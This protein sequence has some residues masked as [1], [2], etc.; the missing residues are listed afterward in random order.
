MSTPACKRFTV[1]RQYGGKLTCNKVLPP[2]PQVLPLIEALAEAPD[3]RPHLVDIF[4]VP[5]W[6]AAHRRGGRRGEAGCRP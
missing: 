4:D 1:A 5:G 6:L 2:R 3:V